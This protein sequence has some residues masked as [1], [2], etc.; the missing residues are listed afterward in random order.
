MASR[1]KS[2]DKVMIISGSL[3]GTSATVVSLNPIA[4]TAKLEGIGMKSRKL[5]PSKL[6]PMGGE[7]EVHTPVPLHNLALVI[8]AKSSKISRIGYAY[9]AAG[10]KIRV[11]R[12]LNN[13][14]IK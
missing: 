2:G 11:A 7:I 4:N 14:E 3:K 12:Q 1:I 6:R 8:D 10:K 13:K 9:N 5:K